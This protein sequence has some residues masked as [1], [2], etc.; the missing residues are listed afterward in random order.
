VIIS[1]PIDERVILR[2]RM[3]EVDEGK[4][5]LAHK[6]VASTATEESLVQTG[7]RHQI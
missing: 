4:K 1:D 3:A 7:N 2:E 6:L 5:I